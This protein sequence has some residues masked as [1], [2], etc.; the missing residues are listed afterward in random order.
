M[1]HDDFILT[2]VTEVLQQFINGI[3]ILPQNMESCAISEYLLQS[4]FLKMTGFQEQK[5]KCICWE[6]A[7]DDYDY[8]YKRYGNPKKSLGECS[9]IKDKNNVFEDLVS[10]ILKFDSSAAMDTM[11]QGDEIVKENYEAI[12]RFYSS[13]KILNA[14]SREFLDF[15][16]LFKDKEGELITKGKTNILPTNLIEFMGSLKISMNDI[17]DK[18]VYRY[19]NRCAHNLF[20]YQSNKPSMIK[21]GS[22]EMI[23]NNIFIDVF[24]IMLM[25]ATYVELYK[26]Y[27]QLRNKIRLA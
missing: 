22:Q 5:C 11:L 17:Y 14:L 23:L 6:L 7:S 13:S 12:I 2:P 19:R 1:I 9:N 3:S 18:H 4:L 15:Q 16:I 26:H 25:D 27:V 10:Q 21:L 20:S 24:I 8:R